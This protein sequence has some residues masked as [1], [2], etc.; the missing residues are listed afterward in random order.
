MLIKKCLKSLKE[1][2]NIENN[3]QRLNKGYKPK[4]P[5]NKLWRVLYD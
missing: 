5:I 3:M 1:Y 2:E 4:Y